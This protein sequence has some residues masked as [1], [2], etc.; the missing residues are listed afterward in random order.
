MT[1]R[2]VE[3]L[4]G[5]HTVA[6]E[7]TR[8]T[9]ILLNHYQVPASLMSFNSFNQEGRTRQLVN[10]LEQ[11]HDVA[12]VS[13]AGTPGISDP[14]FSLVRAAVQAEIPVHPVP[15]ASALLAA[16]TVSGLPVDRFVFEGFLPRKK[17]RSTLLSTL[18]A[19]E[20]AIVIFE[21]PHRIQKT[22]TDL[23]AVLGDRPAAIGRE[24]TK[25][26]EEVLRGTLG[27][28]ARSAAGRAWKGEITLVI[29]R[30]GRKAKG[31]D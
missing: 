7:D 9:R 19:E 30:P 2:S 10:L 24:L 15:G 23:H 21:S 26:H 5:A 11:G 13:D 14:L 27:E 16:L 4:K 6:A 18:A 20:R 3:I 22:L 12:L 25:V 17:G 29:G 1:Y 8:R 28:L 31:G